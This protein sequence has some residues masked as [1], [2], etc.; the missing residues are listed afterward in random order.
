MPQQNNSEKRRTVGRG[1]I[2]LW[3]LCFLDRAGSLTYKK[4]EMN[5]FHTWGKCEGEKAETE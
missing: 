5:I 4:C 3:S 1:R 2:N